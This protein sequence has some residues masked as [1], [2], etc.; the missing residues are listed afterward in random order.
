MTVAKPGD[1]PEAPMRRSIAAAGAIVA[2]GVLAGLVV[3]GAFETAAP[4]AS[5]TPAQSPVALDDTTPTPPPTATPTIVVNTATPKPPPTPSPTP[6]LSI[7]I[8]TPGPDGIAPPIPPIE[9][10]GADPAVTAALDAAVAELA[11]LNA[12][13]FTTYVSGRNVMDLRSGG[14]DLGLDGSLTTRPSVAF[15]AVL[16]FRLVEFECS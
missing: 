16:G 7:T 14:I 15:D 4:S 13:R 6:S 12:Y 1:R 11:G 3:G 9:L 2:A 8:P 5:E 10:A